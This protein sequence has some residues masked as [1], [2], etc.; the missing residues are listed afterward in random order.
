MRAYLAC[1]RSVSHLQHCSKRGRVKRKEREGRGGKRGDQGKQSTHLLWSTDFCPR[2]QEHATGKGHSVHYVTL[3]IHMRE[4]ETGP[5]SHAKHR[6]QVT[7]TG[8]HAFKTCMSRAITLVWT[9]AFFPFFFFLLFLVRS[10]KNIYNNKK[11][12]NMTEEQSGQTF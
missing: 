2:W 6:R 11:R 5:L 4:S 9:M 3:A 10:L 8:R 12:S 1:T 7:V